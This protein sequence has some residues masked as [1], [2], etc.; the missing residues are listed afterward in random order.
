[1]G[2]SLILSDIHDDLHANIHVRPMKTVLLLG[3][4]LSLILGVTETLRRSNTAEPR[5]PR[6]L[7]N[8]SVC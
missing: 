7:D 4:L 5:T 6:D 2:S 3:D 1:M 8:A